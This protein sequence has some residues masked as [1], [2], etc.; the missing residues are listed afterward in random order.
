MG[1]SKNIISGLDAIALANPTR[2]CIPPDNSAGNLSLTSGVN[3]T[4][5]NF[6]TATSFACFSD[7]LFGPC[8]NLNAT[9][10]QTQRLSNKAAF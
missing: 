6:S 9:F 4:L 7:I 2:F 3:P 5:R 1:S 8:N 10:F